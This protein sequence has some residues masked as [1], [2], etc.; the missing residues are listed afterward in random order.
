MR[1]EG[2]RPGGA[3]QVRLRSLLHAPRRE[4]VHRPRVALH[5]L[6]LRNRGAWHGCACWSGTDCS[7]GSRACLSACRSCVRHW[8]RQAAVPSCVTRRRRGAARQHKHA[9]RFL[10]GH[11]NSNHAVAGRAQRGRAGSHGGGARAGARGARRAGQVHRRAARVLLPAPALHLRRRARHAAAAGAAPCLRAAA[12]G[13]AWTCAWGAAWVRVGCPNPVLSSTRAAVQAASGWLL[14][15]H[16]QSRNRQAHLG[17]ARPTVRRS[18]RGSARRAG[19]ERGGPGQR[20]AAVLRARALRAHG[21]RRRCAGG[22][23]D[24][25]RARG[26]SEHTGAA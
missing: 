26:S 2:I 8:C 11:R 14:S 16:F 13:R 4:L 9:P 6:S 23:H 25:L 15:W 10:H 3:C 18:A 12:A 22:A 5:C 24:R 7:H 21:R 17:S 19:R 1:A 20:A